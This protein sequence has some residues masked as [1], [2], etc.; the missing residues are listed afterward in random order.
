MNQANHAAS[1]GTLFSTLA[2]L[3]SPAQT[4]LTSQPAAPALPG[5]RVRGDLGHRLASALE[6]FQLRRQRAR[7]RRALQHLDDHLLRDIGL[8]RAEVEAELPPP[9]MHLEEYLLRDIG[10]ARGQTLDQARQHLWRA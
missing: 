6:A 10:G 2:A 1:L 9:F 4:F 3:T 5:L 7:N 8:S